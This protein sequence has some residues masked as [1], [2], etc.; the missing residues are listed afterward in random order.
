MAGPARNVTRTVILKCRLLSAT[1]ARWC[2]CS[3]VRRSAS[4]LTAGYRVL[5]HDLDRAVVTG[6][7]R[8]RR[9]RSPAATAPPD[10]LLER[11]QDIV[12]IEASRDLRQQCA[13]GAG[14]S[15]NVLLDLCTV[16]HSL[17]RMGAHSCLTAPLAS[18]SPNRLLVSTCE[19]MRYG[20][21]LARTASV[22]PDVRERA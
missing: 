7:T 11:P 18:H 9:L 8:P 10:G 4:A 17:G 3:V 14:L 22:A 15:V 2:C 6:L 13:E 20:L 12:W 21:P 16:P 19:K 5:R 1:E